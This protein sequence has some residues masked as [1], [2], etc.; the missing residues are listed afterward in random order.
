MIT[1]IET[2]LSK[3]DKI[4]H[5]SDV[6][7]RNLKRHEEYRIVFSRLYDYI[8]KTK[9][10]NSVI[11]L[12]GD[13]VHSKTDISPESVNMVQDFFR[14][15]SEICLTICIPGNHD[16]NLNNRSRLDSLTPIVKAIGSDSFIYLPD[17]GVYEI[18]GIH[19][20]VMSVFDKPADFIKADS[21]KGNFKIALHHGAVDT[22]VTDTGHVL[23]NKNVNIHTFSG[24]DL[25]LLGDIHV[26]N[27]MLNAAKT[28]A[29]PGSLIQQSF[30]ESELNRGIL[31]WDVESKTSEFVCIKNDY[32]YHT[33][34]LTKDTELQLPENLPANIRLRLQVNA[35]T[36]ESK[37]SGTISKVSSKCKIIETT[38]QKVNTQLSDLNSGTKINVGDVRDIEYQNKLLS[39][40]LTA[41]GVSDE[42]IDGV[43]H[44]NRKC[45]SIVGASDQLRNVIWVPISFNF[46][47]M[48]SYGND[49]IIKFDDMRGMYGIFA[50]NASGKSSL[51]DALAYC[52]FDKCN[53][54]TKADMVLNN[55]SNSFESEFKFTI[56]NELYT[57]TR[58]GVKMKD[59]VRVTVNFTK[60]DVNGELIVLNGK[61]RTDTN[62]IIR[63]YLGSYEDFVLTSLSVQ[64]NNTGFIDIGQSKRKDLLAQFMDAEIFEKLYST[65]AVEIKEVATE[66]KVLSKEDYDA[67]QT[68]YGSELELV[69][70]EYEKLDQN[71]LK[72]TSKLKETS[73]EIDELNSKIISIYPEVKYTK[74]ELLDLIAVSQKKLDAIQSKIIVSSNTINSLNE[75]KTQIEFRLQDRSEIELKFDSYN[76]AV[77][78]R[79]ELN[80]K[81]K[82]LNS[83]KLHWV[84]VQQRNG[85]VE[86]DP[87]CKFCMSNES[88]L[89]S[90]NVAESLKTAE[91]EIEKM[92]ILIESVLDEIALK[93]KFVDAHNQ[94][95]ID[96]RELDSINKKIHVLSNEKL[97]LQIEESKLQSIVN[98]YIE[99]MELLN[100]HQQTIIENDI[101]RSKIADLREIHS[102]IS[103][104]LSDEELKIRDVYSRIK[105]CKDKLNSIKMSL[106]R[107]LT[108]KNEFNYY[109]L[110]MD[111]V[112]RDGIPYQLIRTALP[113]IEQEVNTILSQITD[114]KITFNCDGKNID[115][116]IV[117][118]SDRYWPLELSSGMEKFVAQIAI[119]TALI[120]VS[121]LPRPPFLVIDEG[122][123]NLDPSNLNNMAMLFDYL[124]TQ[125]MYV[126]V[127]SHIDTVRDMVDSIIEI[128][129]VDNKSKITYV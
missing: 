31:V 96:L 43:K 20:T 117:Y 53:R 98:Q 2:G 8:R 14:S 74:D 105:I 83:E 99:Y 58:T 68:Y 126:I 93:S 3:I 1:K 86:Y 102:N 42:M 72:L 5:I 29:Y 66:I 15:L 122:L 46:S 95:Q 32:G 16:C 78:Y 118:D 28:I 79:D 65:A 10:P 36:P 34:D 94:L 129:K 113:H 45:N 90:I 67:G 41:K 25:T 120:N 22:A 97:Q 70:V 92:S 106:N 103:K 35:L 13:I 84:T 101:I 12:G 30:G 121:S 56:N 116:Y 17:S 61:E 63:S 60:M 18:G 108:L 48:F 100:T 51:F 9:T 128:H 88:V 19:F 39:T 109:E 125:F 62:R 44:V 69:E 11:F 50:S 114:Y 54:T 110:Y 4:Y 115:A 107:L 77:R 6:H 91:I 55:S 26:P 76:R 71:K 89:K 73:T 27:Q 119:R 23:E 104:I 49:N 7:V 112:S 75:S 40:Y 124:K 33:I 123:G 127:I 37:I 52:I 111:A 80:G 82:L 24:Y 87:N 21:F 81:L 38:I 57:I 47:N 85:V 64:N 59:H